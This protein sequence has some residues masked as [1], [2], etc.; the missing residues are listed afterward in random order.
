MMEDAGGVLPP[1]RLPAMVADLALANPQP[2]D[3]DLASRASMF[4]RLPQVEQEWLAH[5]QFSL[6]VALRH[7]NG[8][9]AGLLA[10]GPKRSGLPYSA[11]TVGFCRRSCQPPGSRLRE[12]AAATPTRLSSQQRANAAIARA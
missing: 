10:L 5:G 11:R 8:S 12:C 3:V 6:L 7:A 9:A 4:L 2:M 1:V